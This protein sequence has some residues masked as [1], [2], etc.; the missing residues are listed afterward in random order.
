[1]NG[2]FKVLLDWSKKFMKAKLSWSFKITTS[3]PTKLPWNWENQG[4]KMA[5]RVAYLVKTYN[6]PRSLI[7]NIY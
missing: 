4:T 5:H 3:C 7:I 1:L 2:L 6:V